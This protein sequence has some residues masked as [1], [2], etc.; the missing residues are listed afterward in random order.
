MIAPTTFNAAS[1]MMQPASDPDSGD[2]PYMRLGDCDDGIQ[3]TNQNADINQLFEWN[4]L[5][6]VPS[7][8]IRKVQHINGASHKQNNAGL[9]Q[10][11][12][13]VKRK[14]TL[15]FFAGGFRHL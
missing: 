13:F 4:L 14:C 8:S 1:V 12:I 11:D 2:T 9:G 7:Q 6:V 10:L 3:S 5:I 15:R